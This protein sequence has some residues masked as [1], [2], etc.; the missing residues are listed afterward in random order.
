METKKCKI[1]GSEKEL[2]Y[3]S[4]TGIGVLDICNDCMVQKRAEGRKK[5]IEKKKK[6][7]EAA[8]ARFTRLSEFTPR[9]LM[10]ELVRRGYQG[11]LTYTEVHEIDISNM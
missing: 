2:K 3:F 11:K 8:T 9:E 10:E 7:E 6:E 5:N 1:C 4:K